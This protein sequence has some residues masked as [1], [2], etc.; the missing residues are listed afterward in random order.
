MEVTATTR[1]LERS[2]DSLMVVF[3]TGLLPGQEA[4][5]LFHKG[6]ALYQRFVAILSGPQPYPDLIG[7]RQNSCYGLRLILKATNEDYAETDLRIVMQADRRLLVTSIY[8][9]DMALATAVVDPV[10]P[11][12]AWQPD[13][14]ASTRYP[15]AVWSQVNLPKLAAT[16]QELLQKTRPQ[17][18]ARIATTSEQYEALS[19]DLLAQL[20]KFT[21]TAQTKTW[22]ELIRPS[23]PCYRFHRIIDHLRRMQAQSRELACLHCKTVLSTSNHVFELRPSHLIGNYINPAGYQHEILT[24]RTASVTLVGGPSLQDTWFQGTCLMWMPL[25][26]WMSWH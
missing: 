1:S 16:A 23:H 15:R 6:S 24:A 13:G 5:F 21:A 11:R 8:S 12:I 9:Q 20:P 2:I 18:N 22:E 17:Y 3:Q 4:S 25:H 14:M 7:R 19:Y 26:G 10:L